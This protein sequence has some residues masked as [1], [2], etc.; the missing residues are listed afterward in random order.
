M[1]IPSREMQEKIMNLPEFKD[2]PNPTWYEVQ[3]AVQKQILR[4]TFGSVENAEKEIT[5]LWNDFNEAN[6]RF[7]EIAKEIEQLESERGFFNSF[8]TSSKI[9]E[10]EKEFDKELQST[11]D[12]HPELKER[13][14]DIAN[15]YEK[16]AGYWREEDKSFI[17]EIKD[18]FKEAGDTIQEIKDG[19]KEAYDKFQSVVDKG[20]EKVEDFGR[21]RGWVNPPS[22]KPEGQGMTDPDK[23]TGTIGLTAGKTDNPLIH[24][25]IKGPLYH[26]ADKGSIPKVADLS[27]KLKEAGMAARGAGAYQLHTQLQNGPQMGAQALNMVR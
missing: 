5:G 1:A 24:E 15:R 25:A 10:L 20:W 26:K 22:P 3:E 21:E 13:T 2:N 14:E 19:V 11:Y 9:K 17:Q 23:A 12:K 27:E 16:A 8:S 6:P 18:G 4:D 7:D